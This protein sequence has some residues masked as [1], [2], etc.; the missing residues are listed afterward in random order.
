MVTF[1]LYLQAHPT[2]RKKQ[3]VVFGQML[4]GKKKSN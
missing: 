1:Y 4:K 2:I 3:I